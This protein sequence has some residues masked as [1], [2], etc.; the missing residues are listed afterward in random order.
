MSAHSWM[1]YPVEKHHIGKFVDGTF[2]SSFGTSDR[3]TPVERIEHPVNEQVEI[4]KFQ[5]IMD[6]LGKKIVGKDFLGRNADFCSRS[7]L[8]D[9]DKKFVEGLIPLYEFDNLYLISP[10]IG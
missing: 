1:N 6:K 2:V 8:S 7:N 4:D 9:E 3:S 5:E 10:N